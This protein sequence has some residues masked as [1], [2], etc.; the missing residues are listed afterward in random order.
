MKNVFGWNG[1]RSVMLLLMGLLAYVRGYR[2]FPFGDAPTTLP[3]GLELLSSTLSISFW[4]WTWIAAGIVATVWAFIKYDGF[5][6]GAVIG[7]MIL[8]GVAYVFGFVNGLIIGEMNTE[9]VNMTTYIIPAI[10][11]AYFTTRDARTREVG[12]P[13][14]RTAS[15]DQ[16]LW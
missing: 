15:T 9:Y 4:G 3:A 7:M 5:G 8:W 12:E 16:P 13:H 11:I 1:G 10:V 2:Y 6:W 14:A